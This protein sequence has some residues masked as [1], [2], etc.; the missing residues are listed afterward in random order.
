MPDPV[1]WPRRRRVFGYVDDDDECSGGCSGGGGPTLQ[2]RS[3]SPNVVQLKLSLYTADD[4]NV[5]SN[6][7][8]SSVDL[9]DQIASSATHDDDDNYPPFDGS[10]G[11]DKNDNDDNYGG[12]DY[13]GGSNQDR[14]SD[15]SDHAAGRGGTSG[16]RGRRGRRRPIR[17][18]CTPTSSEKA[19]SPGLAG[20]RTTCACPAG[21]MASRRSCHC[22]S[23]TSRSCVAQYRSGVCYCCHGPNTSR[24]QC[25]ARGRGRHC[26]C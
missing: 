9:L 5:D 15:N 17:R 18:T 7:N 24:A 13:Y 8:S 1:S 16:R 25:E 3:Y 4:G 20:W 10:I 21:T 22:S 6:D 14:K 23:S 2:S 11:G 19:K 26:S 12:S